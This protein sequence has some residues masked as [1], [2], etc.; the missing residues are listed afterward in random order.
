MYYCK[1]AYLSPKPLKMLLF[2]L[3][4]KLFA[5]VVVVNDIGPPTSIGDSAFGGVVGLPPPVEF[6]DIL[7]NHKTI[8]NLV[9]LF[10]IKFGGDIDKITLIQVMVNQLNLNMIVTWIVSFGS[11]NVDDP[12]L[13]QH[14][15]YVLVH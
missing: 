8:S 9:Q 12:C 15:D 10:E 13:N 11:M 7:E 3:L 5:R 4:V 6:C 1:L 14:E 2:I